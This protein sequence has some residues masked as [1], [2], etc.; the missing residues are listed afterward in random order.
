MITC[1]VIYYLFLGSTYAFFAVV[2]EKILCRNIPKKFSMTY[3][4]KLYLFHTLLFPFLI[5]KTFLRSL[6]K[7]RVQ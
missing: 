1:S 5:L 3:V 7:E 2:T 6:N 4:V